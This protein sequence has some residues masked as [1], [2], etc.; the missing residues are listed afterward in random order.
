MKYKP[1]LPQRW[2]NDLAYLFGLLIG[3][4]SMPKTKSKRPNGKY[5]ERYHIYF[6][7]A[8]RDFI[9]SIYNPLFTSLFGLVPWT[10]IRIT[11][12][13][14]LYI[15]RI[16]SKE[17][18]EFLQKKGFTIGRKARIATVPKMPMKYHIYF[19]AGL[20]DTDGGKKGS[21]FGLCTASEFLAL[22]CMEQFKK[23]NIPFHSCP[24]KYRDYIYQQVYTK[25]GDMWK[26]LKTFPIKHLDKIA[27]IESNSPQ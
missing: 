16:E 27:F 20:F 3:D 15:S 10:E 13:V 25:K 23:H 7:S 2:S 24:W 5:Q 1:H 8:S 11:K 6:I 9:D 22:F 26:V 18:Y 21:G 17:V 19:L 12:G 4:G 14:K